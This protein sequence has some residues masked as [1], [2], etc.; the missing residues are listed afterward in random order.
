V[1]KKQ[2]AQ[3]LRRRDIYDVFLRRSA[4]FLERIGKRDLIRPRNTLIRQINSGIRS[5]GV[6]RRGHN[7]EDIHGFGLHA[8]LG[9]KKSIIRIVCN[10][11]TKGRLDRCFRG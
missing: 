10:T 2:Y 6:T 1:V 3:H 11:A 8:K 5:F 4:L 7:L 9:R